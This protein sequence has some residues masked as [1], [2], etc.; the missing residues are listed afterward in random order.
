[1]KV[2]HWTDVADHFVWDVFAALSGD[3][4]R[5]LAPEASQQEAL[6]AHTDNFYVI[7]DQFGVVD[8]HLL[9]LPKR[10]ATS[11]ACLD[12]SLDDEVIWL[13]NHVSKIVAEAYEAHT[14]VAEHGE[15]GCGTNDQA[16]IHVLPIPGMVTREDLTPVI[17]EVLARRLAGIERIVYRDAEFT[18]LEDLRQLLSVDGAQI[19]GE[20]VRSADLTMA[21]V[22]PSA[23]S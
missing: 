20:Q 22:Y 8:G 2:P 15:C 9:V 6:L 23:A 13:L 19:I 4:R 3:N 7:P 12:R 21:G 16:H 1:M 11:I 5:R 10:P 18:A 14:V 17:D